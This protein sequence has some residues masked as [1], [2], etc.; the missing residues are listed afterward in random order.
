MP[1]RDASYYYAKKG[2]R[3]SN[4]DYEVTLIKEKIETD[5]IGNQIST[6]S[7]RTVLCKVTAVSK[8]DFYKA[9]ISN[10]HPS[11]IIT[12][13]RYEYENER[14]LIYEGSTYMVIR[15]FSNSVEETELT[16]EELIYDVENPT[17]EPSE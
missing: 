2:K 7:K 13:K 16:C 6:S 5:E 4:Y 15:T 14:K 9:S 10:L 1:V 3:K 8:E 11:I 17:T 12:V